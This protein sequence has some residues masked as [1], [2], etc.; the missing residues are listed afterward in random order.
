MPLRVRKGED[1]L[2]LVG[3]VRL[4]MNGLLVGLG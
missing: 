4:A 1:V 3:Q 2:D